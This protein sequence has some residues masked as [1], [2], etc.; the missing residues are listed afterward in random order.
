LVPGA[1]LV[2]IGAGWIG[3][4]LA[5]VAAARGCTVTVIEAAAAPLAG[6]IGAEVGAATAPWYE[7]AGV[8]VALGAGVAAGG[9]G[10]RA[11]G[12]RGGTGRR[13]LAGRRRDSHRGRSKTRRSVARIL[14]PEAGER[15]CGGR[16]PASLRS[17][18]VCGRGLRSV[19]VAQVRLPDADRALGRRAAR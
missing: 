4:E 1:R 3:A 9:E 17:E 12:G 7:Q 16:V 6:A 14:G 11:L 19:L 18:R 5:T 10:G 13:R 2:V 15:R 8:G